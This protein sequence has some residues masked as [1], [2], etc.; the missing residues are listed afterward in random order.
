LLVLEKG[1]DDMLLRQDEA[2]PH[3]RKKVA[4]FRAASFHKNVFAGVGPSL[5]H[6]VHLTLLP[7]IFFFWG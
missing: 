5:G 1:P 3:F 6:L 4:D 7:L 2:P